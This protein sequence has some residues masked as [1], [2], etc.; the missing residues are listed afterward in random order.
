[1]SETDDFAHVQRR[2]CAVIAKS[3]WTSS[4]MRMQKSGDELRERRAKTHRTANQFL[5]GLFEKR[6][7]QDLIDDHGA[8]DRYHKFVKYKSGVNDDGSDTL[9]EFD[10]RLRA[11]NQQRQESS[12]KNSQA[13]IDTSLNR[14]FQPET[15]EL[16]YDESESVQDIV[17]EER[18]RQRFR[19]TH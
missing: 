17:A 14:T 15:N 10:R 19:T 9:S 2:L 11:L 13:D 4:R 7:D 6:T 18:V 16:S 3:E 12:R 5:Q 8:V 1:M